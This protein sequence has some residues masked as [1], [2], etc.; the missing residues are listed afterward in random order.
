MRKL[1]LLEHTSLDGFVAGPNGEMDWISTSEEIFD[2]TAQLTKEADTALYGRVTYQMMEGY[3]PTAGDE[4]E[5]SRHDIEHSKWYK[6]ALKVVLSR[7]LDAEHSAGTRIISDNAAD[8]IIKLKVGDGK[9]ILIVGS[10]T[11]VHTLMAADLIDDYWIFINPVL[12]GQGIPLFKS[13]KDRLTLKFIT[14]N[15]F[16]IGVVCLHY[17]RDGEK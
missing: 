3:W 14:Q 8:E 13:I 11:V 4:P 2:Y 1:V 12:L 9:N 5:A 16:P 6:S 15:V 17:K 10:P 7:T